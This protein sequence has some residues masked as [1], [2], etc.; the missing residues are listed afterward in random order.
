[1]QKDKKVV[2]IALQ[3]LCAKMPMAAGAASISTTIETISERA[4]SRFP[5]E[6]RALY[7]DGQTPKLNWLLGLA[8]ISR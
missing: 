2:E 3:Q 6:A 5:R 1:V 7:Y 8:V 4:R